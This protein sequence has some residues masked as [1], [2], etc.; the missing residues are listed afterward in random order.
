MGEK[1]FYLNGDLTIN[2]N[3]L[4]WGPLQETTHIYEMAYSPLVDEY[5]AF[6]IWIND[7]AKY[8]GNYDQPLTVDVILKLR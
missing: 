6:L 3:H 7:P 2:S 1:A 5:T 4:D 8:V